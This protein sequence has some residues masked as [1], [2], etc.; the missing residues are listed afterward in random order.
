MRTVA[1]MLLNLWG[2]FAQN[3]GNT[4]VFFVKDYELMEWVQ[5]KRYELTTFD[6]VSE[7]SMRLCL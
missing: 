6:F 7:D 4:K 2:K 5:D 3:E 1:K